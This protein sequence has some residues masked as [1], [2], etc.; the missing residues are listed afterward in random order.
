MAPEAEPDIGNNGAP[1]LRLGAWEGPL[2]LL[3]ELARAQRVDLAQ[4]SIGALAE[5]CAAAVEE[6]LARGQVPLPRLAEWHI[7]AA[8]LALLRTRLL[9]PE[10]EDAA[11]QAEAATLRQRLADRAA[12]RR[13]AD[14]LERRPQL[15]RNVFGRGEAEPAAGAP[16]A[17]DLTSLLRAC[18]VLL[19]LPA[20]DR[21]YRPSPP[22]L[23]RVPDALAHMRR[24]LPAVPGGAA[25]EAFLPAATGQG[26]AARLQR[27]AAIASTLVAGLELSREGATVL[28]QDAAFGGITVLPALPVQDSSAA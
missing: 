24:L 20:R 19:D 8:W 26:P 2:D 11:E 12:A 1:A 27:R 18:L 14:W 17:A 10:A 9:L 22:P 3:L 13:L 5:Q 28:A 21:V 25:L 4:L 16:P 23:W 6:A 7:M 15:G